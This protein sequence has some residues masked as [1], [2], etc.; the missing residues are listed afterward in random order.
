MSRINGPTYLKSGSRPLKQRSNRYRG[1]RSGGLSGPSSPLLRRGLLFLGGLGFLAALM[2]GLYFGYRWTTTTDAFAL[3]EIRVEGNERLSYGDVLLAGKVRLGQNCLGLN[4]SRVEALLAKNPW[5]ENV[6]VRR[7]LPGRL[8]VNITEKK[9]AYWIR[10]GGI[11]YY[12]DESGEL[13][14]AVSPA[15]FRSLPVLDVDSAAQPHIA[16]IPEMLETLRR[17]G[18]PLSSTALAW[19]RLSGAG[20]AEMFLDDANLTLTFA[21]EDWT[22]ELRL[23][24][25]VSMDLRRRGEMDGVRRITASGGKVWVGKAP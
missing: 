13:I 15:D 21:L 22:S 14:V 23:V 6:S 12:A 11:L 19:I 5:V 1:P 2:A 9:P 24:R 25:A 10:R 20:Q 8:I 16:E 3:E 4:V 17:G 18:L 7:E